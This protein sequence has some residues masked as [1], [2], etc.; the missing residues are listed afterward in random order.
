[1]P[2][3]VFVIYGCP[4]TAFETIKAVD[5][6]VVP[7]PDRTLY[8]LR[9]NT[10]RI[11]NL[12][13]FS[14]VKDVRLVGCSQEFIEEFSALLAEYPETGFCLSTERNTCTA[15]NENV[16]GDANGANVVVAENQPISFR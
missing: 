16:V 3:A 11:L 13:G 1:M 12:V 14:G 7:E 9:R 4:Y 5:A 15:F 8:H 10:N 6:F 2:K